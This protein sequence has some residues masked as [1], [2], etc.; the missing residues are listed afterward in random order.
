MST[1]RVATRAAAAGDSI[2]DME[3]ETEQ[4]CDGC[5]DTTLARSFIQ[6]GSSM[7]FDQGT[8]LGQLY[9]DYCPK[10]WRTK[11]IGECIR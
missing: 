9:G 3:Y 5:G 1:R 6:I 10:C 7:V 8:M 2:D 4:T 11:P